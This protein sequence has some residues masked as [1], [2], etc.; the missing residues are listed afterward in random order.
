MHDDVNTPPPVSAIFFVTCL[1]ACLAAGTLQPFE[2]RWWTISIITTITALAL[3][4]AGTNRFRRHAVVAGVSLVL[5][6]TSIV[7]SN[8]HDPGD[9]QLT[10]WLGEE[11][12]RA[13]L[14]LQVV[15]GPIVHDRGI[16]LDARLLSIDIDEENR[17][18]SPPP[19][20]RV[21]VPFD[22]LDACQQMPL[23]GDRITLWASIKRF[24]PASTPWQ[25]SQRRL[26]A[27]RGYAATATARE[28]YTF[29][30]GE[31]SIAQRV[32]RVLTVR[33]I[34]LERR[35]G[36]HLDGDRRAVATA[37][38]TGSRGLLT[39]EF[40]EPFNVTSTGHILAI[41]GL[42]F[43]VIAGLVAF[44][45]RLVLDRFPRIYRRWPR[46]MLVGIAT[47][48]V[49][50]AYLLAIGAPVSARRA[51]GMTALAIGVVCFSPWRLRPLSALMTTAAVLLV[52]Q[53]A[54]V[55]EPGYQLSVSATAG[56]LLF[57]RYRPAGLRRPDIPG[58]D[59][60]SRR[61]R[62][63]RRLLTFGGMS[64]SA[65]I[66][67][68]PILLQMTGEIAVAGLWT[69]LVVIPLVG[70]VLFPLLVAGAL[71]T[72]VL[73]IGAAIC[74][75]VATEGLMALRVLVDFA[76][77]A[78]ASVIRWGTPTTMQFIGALCAVAVAI[79][80]GLRIRAVLVAAAIFGLSAT[81]AMIADMG[82]P[83]QVKIHAIDVGQGD[84]T[85]I[86][87]PDGTTVLIDGGGRPV[88]RDPGLGHVVPYLRHRGIDRLDAV[89]LTH[90]DY[91]HYGGLFAVIRPFSPR[92]LYFDNIDADHRHVSRLRREMAD[93]G[94][95]IHG[96][97]SRHIIATDDVDIHVFR[98]DIPGAS[99]NDRSL[100]VRL[101][102]ASAGVLLAGDVEADGE[103]WLVD[104]FAEPA[105]LVKA[106]HHGSN[107]SSSPA[108]LDHFRPAVAIASAG[109]HNQF[110]HPHPAVIDRYRERSIDLLTT[111][112]RGSVVASIDEFGVLR[113][114]TAR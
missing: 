25:Y 76:A 65:T 107:T 71:L 93:A 85:L 15:D 99:D 103:A 100:V 36:D 32:K 17:W 28:A 84:A 33:R 86:E 22:P 3:V 14:E 108:F 105:A 9:H 8:H 59:T 64:L 24:A 27:G 50:V 49:L 96:V 87:A 1:S 21:F 20:I 29:V 104:R 89:V 68:W 102:Y 52:L 92:K 69:N 95:E 4:S 101:S 70:S 98:P 30:E 18:T 113:I 79:I 57:M 7:V 94:A 72:G 83:S 35:L 41:S 37:M 73:D 38:L 2:L 54:I 111:A 58:P 80:G 66:A 82:S 11:R 44:G 90:A 81:P 5:I 74:L 61:Q 55:F 46:R 77:Y 78:P 110:G 45:I 48:V 23:A 19:T 67:T 53:P 40:R 112:E 6:H 12:H 62:W 75:T 47:L 97:A 51:F 60:E 43:G 26:M 91:D 13:E 88:G 56:I 39:P 16:S 42:H 114:R 10:S 31:W 109:R 63:F 34:E 106:P